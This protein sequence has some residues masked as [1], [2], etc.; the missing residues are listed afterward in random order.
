[1]R[2]LLFCLG[3]VGALIVP[4]AAFSGVA[5]TSQPVVS[6]GRSAALKALLDEHYEQ[7]LRES[8]LTASL[9]GDDRY[10][11]MLEDVGPGA[12]AK[13]R[14]QT[15]SRLERLKT[16]DERGLG[17]DDR[18]DY[19]LLKL[20]L[21]NDQ[22]GETFFPEQLPLDDRSGPHVWL[23]QMAN[24][25]R[26]AKPRDYTDFAQRLEA[27]PRL[28]DQHIANMRAG[29][30]AGRV[31]P[32]VAMVASADQ[33]AALASEAFKA[34]PTSSPFYEPFRGRAAD[35]EAAARAR[36]AI[37]T[38]IIP[39]YA[40]L[41][42]FI[43]DEY[44]PGCRDTIG[45]SDG[46]DG[47]AGYDYALR[48]QTTTDLS[49]DQ[50]HS[51]G[52]SEVARIR[53]EMFTV[54]AR[55]DFPGKVGLS[56]DALF[57]AF[58]NYLRTDP[59]FYH[60]SAEALLQGY[61]DL[62]KRIDA[63]MPRFFGVLPRNSYGV[64]PIPRFAAPSSPT[65]YYYPGSLKTG[66]PGYFLANT[67][68]LDQRPRYEMTALTMHEAV[69]GHH[70]QIALA[71]EL[72]G[73]HPFRTMLGFTVFVEGWALYAERLG[74]EAG[75]GPVR[76]V[77]MADKIGGTEPAGGQGLYEDPYD[78][79]GRLT[80]EMWRAARLVV[81]TGIHALGWS[82]EKAI[83]FLSA[84][85]ALSKLN[86]EREVDRYIAWPGQATAYKLGE[87]KIRQLRREAEVALGER[88]DLRS[89]HDRVLGAGAVPVSL[90]EA[91]IR[92]W[93]AERSAK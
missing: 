63:E 36:V 7:I 80:Y 28:I 27:V 9:R 74:L 43:R 30:K 54:I 3:I 26:F 16:L 32:K 20:S 18:V 40:R 13:S 31:Q 59:R 39:A 77:A 84:N 81:D 11:G 34:D 49:A 61:R 70:H 67:H 73:V 44:V 17:E 56:G 71:D 69:P 5:G 58:V 2:N 24:Q 12:L 60:Q 55:S 15:K 21:E 14:A 62:A 53:A 6:P 82:R 29:L 92:A 8:P 66:V 68:A 33:A 50:I 78:D 83:A 86:I 23:P 87:M 25:L 75:G 41:A 72:E 46:V 64:R 85:T 10:N 79:F 51:I 1:M 48:V 4:T 76:R 65:A 22:L 93:I 88:F 37:S 57:D 35:D 91:R 38:G 90:L 52:V 89:F 19:G 45:A 42:A 47:R